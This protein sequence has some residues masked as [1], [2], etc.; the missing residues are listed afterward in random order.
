MNR[1]SGLASKVSQPGDG[2][3]SCAAIDT[4]S[5]GIGLLER[6]RPNCFGVSVSLAAVASRRLTILVEESPVPA[7][8]WSA[9]CGGGTRAVSYSQ[10]ASWLCATGSA[11]LRNSLTVADAQ[12]RKLISDACARRR[13]AKALRPTLTFHGAPL[14]TNGTVRA[15]P[16]SGLIGYPDDNEFL[17][18]CL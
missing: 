2:Y 6:A 1:R 12:R 13:E 18:D 9:Q 14:A 5:V 15:I 8:L 4:S 16:Q 7:S 3:A 11:C 10:L 17:I